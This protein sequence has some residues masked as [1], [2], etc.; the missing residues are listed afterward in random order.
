MNYFVISRMCSRGPLVEVDH[1][2]SAQFADFL[3]M[4][5]KIHDEQIHRQLQDDLVDHL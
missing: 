4:H 1:E 2:V 5:Q 3:I